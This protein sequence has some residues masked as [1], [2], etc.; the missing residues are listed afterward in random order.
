MNTT[1]MVRYIKEILEELYPLKWLVK[2]EGRII[3]FQIPNSIRVGFNFSFDEFYTYSFYSFGPAER[4]TKKIDCLVSD[5]EFR[6][7]LKAGVI[8]AFNTQ[9]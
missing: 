1:A 5:Q 9:I 6:S 4:Y 2:R 7:F 3:I 8:E